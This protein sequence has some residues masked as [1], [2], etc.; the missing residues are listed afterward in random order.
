V[1]RANK[2]AE[3]AAALLESIRSKIGAVDELK[4][5]GRPL[6]W[7]LAQSSWDSADFERGGRWVLVGV[8]TT[9]HPIQVWLVSAADESVLI[10][11]AWN[12]ETLHAM[13]AL[14]TSMKIYRTAVKN[15]SKNVRILPMR[16]EKDDM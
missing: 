1:R 2:K 15:K 11:R 5:D 7:Q 10:N 14:G 8:K 4:F 16:D 3:A 9:E 6:R 12:D 13:P